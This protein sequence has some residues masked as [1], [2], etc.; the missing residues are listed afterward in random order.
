MIT[1]DGTDV[2]KNGE[3]IAT[4]LINVWRRYNPRD[5][6]V[7]TVAHGS[8]GELLETKGS[9]CK[10]RVGEDVGFVTYW[11]IKELKG[12]FLEARRK[13]AEL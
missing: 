3:W 11:F 5:E 10:V 9:V 6:V 13:G 8:Q 12:K 1:F 4:P 2:D 7:A